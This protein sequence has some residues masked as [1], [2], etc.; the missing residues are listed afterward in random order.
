MKTKYVNPTTGMFYGIKGNAV[1]TRMLSANWK[2]DPKLT[3]KEFSN[4]VARGELLIRKDK[5]KD[6]ALYSNASATLYY[7]KRSNVYSKAEGSDRYSQG[8][9]SMGEFRLMLDKGEITPLGDENPKVVELV[10]ADT[11]VYGNSTFEY[12]RVGTEL[13]VRKVGNQLF[14]RCSLTTLWLERQIRLGALTPIEP[15]NTTIHK[16]AIDK[17]EKYLKEVSNREGESI[18]VDTYDFLVANKVFCP[19]T[20]HA[21]KKILDAGKRGAKGWEKDID[22]AIN[23]L[24][25]AKQLRPAMLKALGS[26]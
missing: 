2:K 8:G 14:D 20:A 18:T 7:I 5:P 11:T 3:V 1:Y 15:V 17:G 13:Y 12:Q 22:E 21:V 19:A 4:A 16:E 26:L 9:M 6:K 10:K 23:S 25:R 24:E